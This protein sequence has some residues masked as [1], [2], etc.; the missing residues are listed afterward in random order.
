[1]EVRGS[2][3]NIKKAKKDFPKARIMGIDIKGGWMVVRFDK[4]SLILKIAKDFNLK[5]RFV[6]WKD[7]E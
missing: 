1:M 4:H 7:G 5:T 6:N 2:A 3:A